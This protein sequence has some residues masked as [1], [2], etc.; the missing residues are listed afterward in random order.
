MLQMLLLMHEMMTAS[1]H[2][3]YLREMEEYRR[4]LEAERGNR[5]A[6]RRGWRTVARLRCALARAGFAR[7]AAARR[8]KGGEPRPAAGSPRDRERRIA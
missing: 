7:P 3:D 8:A 5:P 6:P 4:V 2:E 1:K